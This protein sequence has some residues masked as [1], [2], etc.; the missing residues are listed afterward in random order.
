M[1][2]WNLEQPNFIFCF[3][4]KNIIKRVVSCHP[5]KYQQNIIGRH[6]F[7]FFTISTK[8]YNNQIFLD[9][10][11]N[12]FDVFALLTLTHQTLW[13]YIHTDM[14]YRHKIALIPLECENCFW[15]LSWSL[16]SRSWLLVLLL[17]L[18]LL[19]FLLLFFIFCLFVFVFRSLAQSQ[20]LEN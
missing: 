18:L 9:F 10:Y 7:T 15:H 6:S 14:S 5:L 3:L 8:H 4:K 13:H 16:R 12:S 17:L 2:K 20:R 19:L 1:T 11:H